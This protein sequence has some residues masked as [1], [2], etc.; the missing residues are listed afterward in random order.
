MCD[1]SYMADFPGRS[2]DFFISYNSRDKAWA[3][4]IAWQ[5]ETAGFTTTI[6]AWD[7]RPGNNFVVEMDRASKEATRTIAV[8]SEH[9]LASS[10]TPPEWATA[11]ADDPM[12]INRS[13]VP[14]RVAECD[15]QGLLGPIVY[16]DLVDLDKDAAATALVSGVQPGRSKPVAAPTFPGSPA[17]SGTRPALPPRPANA[18]VADTLDWRPA[19]DAPPVLWRADFPNQLGRPSSYTVL[20][21]QLVP[22]DDILIPVRQLESLRNDL[23]TIGRQSGIFTASQQLHTDAT[24]DLVMAKS[25][26]GHDSDES[27]LMV[28]RRGQRGAWISLPHDMMGSMFDRDKLPARL[29]PLMSVLAGLDVP[30]AERYAITARMGPVMSL[31]FGDQSVIGSRNSASMSMTGRSD[32]ILAVEDSVRG[33]AIARHASEIAEELVAR[34]LSSARP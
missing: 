12:G 25:V 21:I 14:V 20:E 15:V 11:F 23:S 7:F 27:G 18:P 4:W 3:E 34:L 31:M 17:A 16:I 9:Y 5:L 1:R 2:K 8:L 26:L 30:A 10:F 19:R 24:S 33:D 22:V 32:L 13:V 29:A 28:T 6:Q